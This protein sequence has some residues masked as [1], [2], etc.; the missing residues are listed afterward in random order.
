MPGKG[1]GISRNRSCPLP[2]GSRGGHAGLIRC[3]SEGGH[4]GWIRGGRGCGCDGWIRGGSRGALG[5]QVKFLVGLLVG[6][7]WGLLVGGLGSPLMLV[8]IL[9]AEE[10]TVHE[11][12]N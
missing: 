12:G 4:A 6:A 9:H 1:S 5:A 7:M 8:N 10:A 11:R 2:G 3:G